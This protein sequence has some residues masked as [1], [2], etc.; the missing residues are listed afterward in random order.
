VP[1]QS[2]HE[3]DM[4]VW[5]VLCWP[6]ESQKQQPGVEKLEKAVADRNAR[7]AALQQRINEVKD[8]IFEPFSTKVQTVC[9]GAVAPSSSLVAARSRTAHLDAPD[10]RLDCGARPSKPSEHRSPMTV[11]RLTGRRHQHPGV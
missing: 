10:N 5:S 2:H 7:I 9:I 6:Q 1:L 8:K 11:L 4:F 3:A